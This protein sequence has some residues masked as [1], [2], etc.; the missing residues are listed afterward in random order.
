MTDDHLDQESQARLLG[1]YGRDFVPGELLFSDGDPGTEAYLLQEGRI[2]LIKRVGAAERSLRLLRPGDLFGESALVVG[3]TRS[4]TAVA[5]TAGSMLVIDHHTLE[6]ILST[7]PAVGMRVL[8]Q[9]VRRLR[10]AEDQIEVLMLADSQSK[11]VVT[12]LKLAQQAQSP[13]I[14]DDV[15]SVELTVSPMDISTRV[16]LDLETVKRTVQ[17]L[18]ESG[19]LQI[20]GERVEIPNVA[21]LRELSNLL[22][23]R[24]Q[25]VG[26]PR[27]PS[28]RRPRGDAE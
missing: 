16:G 6:Q 18:K 11:I 8:Q 4:S 15:V 9:L 2:R 28:N 5:A 27:E 14:S 10:D 17:Q 25:I 13:M 1:R 26:M 23:L 7:H 19:H 24:D 20:V 12:L 21:S 22:T 3:A